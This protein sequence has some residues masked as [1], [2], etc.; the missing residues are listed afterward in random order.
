M[1]L[2]LNYKLYDVRM[3]GDHGCPVQYI[4]AQG[5]D[6]TSL[7]EDFMEKIIAHFTKENE[8]YIKRLTSDLQKQQIIKSFIEHGETVT[9]IPF[10]LR[11]L[12]GENYRTFV[13]KQLFYIEGDVNFNCWNYVVD[14]NRILDSL[15]TDGKLIN[16]HCVSHLFKL[17]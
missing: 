12:G 5:N 14:Y 13:C 16:N 11:Y 15:F 17:C 4:I 2:T 1:V 10:L 7:R 6:E 8:K 3:E 9:Q